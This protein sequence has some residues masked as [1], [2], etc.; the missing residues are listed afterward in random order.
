M[1]DLCREE[2]E[3]YIRGF[4]PIQCF[5]LSLMGSSSYAMFFDELWGKQSEECKL[6]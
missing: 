2:Y 1:V 5:I 4:S 3:K 6:R